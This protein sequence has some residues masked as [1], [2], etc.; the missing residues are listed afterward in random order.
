MAMDGLGGLSRRS[1]LQLAGTALAFP[2]TPL[3][4]NNLENSR[5]QFAPIFVDLVRNYTTTTGTGNLVLGDPAPGF[6]SFASVLKPGDMFYY[7]VISLD[8]NG[9]SEVGRGTLQADGTVARDPIGGSLTNFSK[10]TKSVALVT[11]AEWYDSVANKDYVDS[12]TQFGLIAPGA[13]ARS[14][15]AKAADV[16]SVKDFGAIGNGVADDTATFAAAIA[17]GAATGQAIFVPRGTYIVKPKVLALTTVAADRFVMFGDG[18]SSI[19]KV[20][21]NTITAD[22][23]WLFNISP[24]S[25]MELIEFRDLYIDN[26]ARGSTDP[27]SANGDAWAY[28]HCHTFSCAPTALVKQIRFDNVIIKDPAADGFNAS[29]TTEDMIDTYVVNNCAATDRTRVRNDICFTRLPKNAIITGFRGSIIDTEENAGTATKKRILLDNCRTDG[30]AL[31]GFASDAKESSSGLVEVSMSNCVA[32]SVFKTTN[33][34]VKASNCILPVYDDGS[35]S[36]RLNNISPGS[37]FDGCTFRHHYDGSGAVTSLCLFRNYGQSRKTG[38]AFN[39]CRFTIA[40]GSPLDLVAPGTTSL[41]EITN[42]CP[43]AEMADHVIELNNCTF[44]PRAYRS[45]NVARCGTVVA[46]DC[47]WGGTDAAAYYWPQ[48]TANG[49]GTDLTID[50][51]DFSGVSGALVTIGWNDVDQVSAKGYLR[52]R[53]EWCG[54]TTQALLKNASSAPNGTR[55]T[56]QVKSNRRILAP[57]VPASGLVGDIVELDGSAIAAGA[58]DSF[59]CTISSASTATWK[60]RTALAG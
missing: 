42:G 13:V 17:H 40:T 12:A 21:N 11:A 5:M 60:A 6:K 36:N 45:I 37:Q 32:T 47:R 39:N 23:N 49:Y 28:Q 51:G 27:A 34:K 48:A 1:A 3:K 52:L 31:S 54:V 20:A 33:V 9:E 46:R 56:L 58:A 53:G 16:V 26:N 29:G 38:V 14:L 57:A 25:P 10:G 43:M 4:S 55:A 2:A 59:R 7:S 41:I 22:F 15:A 24:S 50:G 30:I 18:G 19:I 35:G 8:S 44:D